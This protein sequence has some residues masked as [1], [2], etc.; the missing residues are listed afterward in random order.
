VGLFLD[1]EPGTLHLPPGRQNGADPARYARQVRAFGNSVSGM[2]PILVT[3][4]KD[5]A[6]MIN[7]G[8]TRATRI[9]YLA[10]GCTVRVEVIDVRPKANFAKLKQVRDVPPPP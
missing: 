10:P 4:G 2:P 5:G 9:H 7:N 8:V 3:L 1:V 6:M